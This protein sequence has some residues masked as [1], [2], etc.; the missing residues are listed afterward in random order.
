[1]R[2]FSPFRSDIPVSP[3]VCDR[4]NCSDPMLQ[5]H[6]Q[7]R[8]PDPVSRDI[9]QVLRSADRL[10]T[11]GEYQE[12]ERILR[13]SGTENP[14]DPNIKLKLAFTLLKMRMFLDAYNLSFDVAKQDPKKR[15]CTSGLGLGPFSRGAASMIHAGSCHVLL[16]LIRT[17]TLR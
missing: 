3:L 1:M 6:F 16:S 14:T 8:G 5:Q 12:A 17:R 11:R 2:F 9:K 13:A 7:C 15:L 10:I 4:G